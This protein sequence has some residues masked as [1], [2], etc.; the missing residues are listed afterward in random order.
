MYAHLQLQLGNIILCP[1]SA[2]KIPPLTRVVDKHTCSRLVGP[3][4]P[5]LANINQKENKTK[6]LRATITG[7]SLYYSNHL[8]SSPSSAT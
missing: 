5:C 1:F 6:Q 8:T 3:E 4:G 2:S 7:L